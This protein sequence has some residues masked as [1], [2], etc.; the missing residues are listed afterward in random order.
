M[1]IQKTVHRHQYDYY[2]GHSFVNNISSSIIPVTP[3]I[4]LIYTIHC[5]QNY[6]L[7]IDVLYHHSS[8]R[9]VAQCRGVQ[10]TPFTTS[11]STQVKL[12]LQ[13]GN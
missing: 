13:H 3:P 2:Q 10:E 1:L 5:T 8:S 4:M 6:S 12:K 7:M 11:K 9:L